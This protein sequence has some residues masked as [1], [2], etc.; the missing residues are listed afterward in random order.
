MIQSA[1]PCLLTRAFGLFTF[2]VIIDIFRL[3]SAFL[4]VF[5]HLIFL[6]LVFFRIGCECFSKTLILTLQRG[7]LRHRLMKDKMGQVF[8][9]L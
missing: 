8:Y 2:N 5:C 1:H 9:T 4:C 7:K 6:S 3:K